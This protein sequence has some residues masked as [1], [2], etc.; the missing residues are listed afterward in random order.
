V[1]LFIEV[2]GKAGD[3]NETMEL[4]IRDNF[5]LKSSFVALAMGARTY[6]LQIGM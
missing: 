2:Y 5:I 4:I 6:P 3:K 1:S